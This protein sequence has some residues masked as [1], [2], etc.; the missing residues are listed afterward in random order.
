MSSSEDKNEMEC[1]RASAEGATTRKIMRAQ[2]GVECRQG[3]GG[4]HFA[5]RYDTLASASRDARNPAQLPAQARAR[6]VEGRE[7][8]RKIKERERKKGTNKKN[9]EEG[10]AE[11]EGKKFKRD[12]SLTKKRQARKGEP[13]ARAEARVTRLAPGWCKVKREHAKE[14]ATGIRK[15]KCKA[16]GT[17][18]TKYRKIENTNEKTAASRASSI[19]LVTRR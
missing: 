15:S 16:A 1:L 3:E 7:E 13:H 12:A 5:L 6:N 2:G 8:D 18:K 19:S 10:E 9:G 4:H 11:H 17:R 14:K